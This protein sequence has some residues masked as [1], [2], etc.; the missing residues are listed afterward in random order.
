MSNLQSEEAKVDEEVV[1]EEAS[2]ATEVNG[3]K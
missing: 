2:E 3:E 1:K